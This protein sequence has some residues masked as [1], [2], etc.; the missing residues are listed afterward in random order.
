MAIVKEIQAK[1]ILRKH[2]RID[3]W[4]ISHYGMNLYRGC[5]HNCA[6]CDGR[7]EKYRVEGV[8]GKELSVKTNAI[9]ILN[10]EL[11]PERKRKPLKN[12]YIFIGGGVSDAY[13]P[14][15]IKYQLSREVLKLCL[16]YN[17]PVHILTK[18]TL[19]LRDLDLIKE[20]N[21]KTR[22]IVSF[23]FS[24]VD[25][26]ISKIFE[27]GVPLPQTRMDAITELKRNGIASGIFL[28]PVIPFIS[29]Y[30]E[31]IDS[32]AKMAKDRQVDFII[33]AGMTL[34]E[35]RQKE[36]FY[37]VLKK[38]YPDLILEYDNLYIYQYL[39]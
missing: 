16:K 15:E 10:R 32:V 19:V 35:G 12:S 11:N 30:P 21:A 8:F 33:F 29:D 9:D 17:F 22:A 39:S 7:A 4:F 18:S 1:S 2:K 24:S 23:S 26:N 34:K 31:K 3:S 28:M 27:P 36:Y 13:Q 20:I 14:A 37:D 5:L 25:E 38:N 6:Y